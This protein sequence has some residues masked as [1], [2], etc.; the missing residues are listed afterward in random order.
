MLSISLLC[1][2]FVIDEAKHS[3]SEINIADVNAL[4]DIIMNK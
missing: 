1:C 4:I 2:L 3:D